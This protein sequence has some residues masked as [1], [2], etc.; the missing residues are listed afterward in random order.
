MEKLQGK[1]IKIALGVARNTP[2]YIWKLEAGR[3]SIEIEVRRRAGDYIIQIL[4]MKEGR[5][6]QICLREEVRE[7]PRSSTRP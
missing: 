7:I 3:R 4:K 1:Y 6:P 2:D 5:R